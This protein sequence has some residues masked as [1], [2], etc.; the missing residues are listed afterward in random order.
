[1]E[2]LILEQSL[3]QNSKTLTYNLGST[4]LSFLHGSES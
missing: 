2:N 4:L 1:M 3:K